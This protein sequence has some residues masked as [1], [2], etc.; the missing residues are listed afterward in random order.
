MTAFEKIKLASDKNRRRLEDEKSLK[1]SYEERATELADGV[2]DLFQ[3]YRDVTICT[4]TGND[5]RLATSRTCVQTCVLDAS[6]TVNVSLGALCIASF[7]CVVGRSGAFIRY[8]ERVVSNDEVVGIV[9]RTI[10]N[11]LE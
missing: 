11:H 3:N 10:L 9:E 4:K 2:C 8:N 6:S 7:L 5:V 1:R